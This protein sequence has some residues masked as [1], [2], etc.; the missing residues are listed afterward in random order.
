MSQN[1]YK[2]RS[3]IY[4]AFLRFLSNRA[5]LVSSIILSIIILMSI[6]A[7]L[8]TPTGYEEQKFLINNLAFPSWE[9]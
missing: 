9:H 4:Y 3:P 5:A 8:I 6:L 1:I 7:P 2:I